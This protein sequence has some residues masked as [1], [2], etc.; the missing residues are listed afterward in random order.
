MKKFF[1]VCQ[2]VSKFT[3][4]IEIKMYKKVLLYPSNS[5]EVYPLF[6]FNTDYVYFSV[7]DN[8]L[9]CNRIARCSRTSL[10]VKQ[11]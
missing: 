5:F 7:F 2:T 11:S 1:Y 4:D 6:F 9:S 3:R 10:Q 8:I